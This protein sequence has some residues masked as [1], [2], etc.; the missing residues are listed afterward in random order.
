MSQ[1][2]Q[3]F[4]LERFRELHA[5]GQPQLSLVPPF[6]KNIMVELSNVCN[7]ACIFCTNS[8]MTRKKGKIS[9]E[10]IKSIFSQAYQLG[11]REV[12][13]YTT[14][15][16]FVYSRIVDVI[17]AAKEAGMTYIYTTT[18]GALATP[19]KLVQSVQA[20]L[21]SIKFS[22]NA[23][24]RETYRKVHG[25]DD[26]DSVINN[27]KFI[28]KY[29]DD[30][31]ISLKIGVSFVVTDLNRHEKV[32]AKMLY[33]NLADNFFFWEEENQGGYMLQ[34]SP[35][36]YNSAPCHMLFNRFHV[37]YEGYFTL[38]CVD[39]QN[40]L[41]V[42]DLNEVS[43]K[44]AWEAPLVQEMRKKHLENKLQGTLCYNCLTGKN[45]KIQPLKEEFATRFEYSLMK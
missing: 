24:S 37:T 19:E 31:G 17:R 21:S 1:L 11:T 39:Y 40:Y 42:A 23:G 2:K 41:A 3:E 7:H 9:F 16:P 22:I 43:L 18:N 27:L 38:C 12:G 13:L 29:R 10:L 5:V 32:M 8:R 33:D 15:E 30:N 45:T 28:R 36:S 34:Y 35:G 25:K 20:G 44:D 6:P 26:Y 4:I 14:G